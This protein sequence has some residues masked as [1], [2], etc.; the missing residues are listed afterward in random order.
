MTM[1]IGRV[2]A[3]SRKEPTVK[4]R[5]SI[6]SW[7]LQMGQPFISR[8]SSVSDGSDVLER[9]RPELFPGRREVR[10][11][12]NLFLINRTDLGCEWVFTWHIGALTLNLLMTVL[13]HKPSSYFLF[14]FSTFNGLVTKTRKEP[15]DLSSH[16]S[17]SVLSPWSEPL[18]F[19]APSLG[20]ELLINKARR[21]IKG[22]VNKLE[23][24]QLNKG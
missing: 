3:D 13:L 2:M 23:G 18:T 22:R 14:I 10:L 7:S 5:F 21:L 12:Q 8:Y 19:T 1:P 15:A 20:D 17:V 11:D 4:A 16:F 6:S 9:L 24:K